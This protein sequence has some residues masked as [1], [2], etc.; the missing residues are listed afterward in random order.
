MQASVKKTAATITLDR[1]V[2]VS[3]TSWK[4]ARTVKSDFLTDIP[5]PLD[6][7][8]L[9][10]SIIVGMVKHAMAV[11][12]KKST[13]DA[14]W[15]QKVPDVRVVA[16]KKLKSGALKLVAL[17]NSVLCVPEDKDVGASS[18][19]IGHIP[20]LCKLCYRS[21]NLYTA[22]QASDPIFVSQFFA[23]R[24]T[25]D[26]DVINCTQQT[27]DVELTVMGQKMKIGIPMMVNTRPILE[28]QEVIVL[29]TSVTSEAARAPPSK[30]PKRK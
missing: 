8:D 27:K 9:K 10:A 5:D 2:L 20:G 3:G 19:L 4:C 23:V 18:K 15:L 30:K 24:E 1:V 25:F 28:E 17:T 21:C 29:K 11:E 22:K 16:S 6:N 26:Q 12:F 7:F 13:E 14:C